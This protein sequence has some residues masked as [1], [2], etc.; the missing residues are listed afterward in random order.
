[1]PVPEGSEEKGNAPSPAHSTEL[2]IPNKQM[3]G[4]AGKQNYGHVCVFVALGLILDSANSKATGKA[5]PKH[6]DAVTNP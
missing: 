1:M 6:R 4:L 3:P 5:G 2:G